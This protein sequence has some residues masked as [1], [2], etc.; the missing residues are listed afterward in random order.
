[1]AVVLCLVA[2]AHLIADQCTGGRAAY[3]AQGATEHGAYAGTYLGA[4]GV[5]GSAGHDEGQGS[6]C[7]QC[8]SA[9]FHGDLRIAAA[10]KRPSGTWLHVE[11]FAVSCQ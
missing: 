11:P 10:G 6:G 4:G 5:G 7:A 1:M 3:G 8:E 9:K 2:L